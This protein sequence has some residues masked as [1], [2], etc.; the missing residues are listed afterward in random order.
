MVLAMRMDSYGLLT[1]FVFTLFIRFSL[2]DTIPDR[3]VWFDQ[4]CS[5]RV[6]NSVWQEVVSFV[7]TAQGSVYSAADS[8]SYRYFD[9]IFKDYNIRD[10]ISGKF[11]HKGSSYAC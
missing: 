8:D 2:A 3:T 1:C 7:N 6:Q 11:S 9:Y 5:Q 4:S 10:F